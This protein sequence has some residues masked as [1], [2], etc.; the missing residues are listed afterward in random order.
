MNGARRIIDGRF[1]LLE[2]LGSGGMGTVW[3][4]RDTVLERDVA[5][6]EVRFA[7]PG[8]TGAEPDTR[9]VQHERVLREGRALARLRHPNVVAIH[10]VVDQDPYP[11]LVMEFVPGLS[12]Q[13]RLDKGP[14]DPRTAARIGRDMLAALRAAHAAGVH[15]RDIK[16]ANILLREGP[17][18][19]TAV[20]TD[21]GIA[22]LPGSSRLTHTGEMVGSPEFMAPERIRGAVD[23][24][25]SDL[26][27]LG[28]TLYVSVEGTSPM[29]RGT[30]LATLAAVLGD[31]VPAPVH[32]GPL[33]PVLARL[34]VAD[35]QDRP[36]VAEL[37]ALLTAVVDE[38][39]RPVAP[40]VR[41]SATVREPGPSAA[42]PLVRDARAGG[43]PDG[44]PPTARLVTPTSRRGP[45]RAGLVVGAAAVAVMLIAAASYLAL[46][47]DENGSARAADGVGAGATVT[48]TAVVPG[49]SGSP[50]QTSAASPG[51]TN[52]AGTTG[53]AGGTSGATDAGSSSDASG[54]AGAEEVAASPNAPGSP[55]STPTA[56]STGAATVVSSF[57]LR[58]KQ[59]GR[60]L[61]A[62]LYSAA[63]R[64]CTGGSAQT[65]SLDS[66]GALKGTHGYLTATAG[67]RVV[68]TAAEYTGD[69]LQHWTPVSSGQ[70]RNDETGDCLNVIGQETADGTQVAL[71][72]CTAK[73]NQVWIQVAR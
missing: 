73:A 2:R 34:L 55:A 69:G 10:H 65:W 21:F 42:T 37:D 26:W 15:H 30:S 64:T 19:T 56:T 59:S 51:S 17:G 7:E 54:A 60:C 28:M 32:A 3:R 18:H 38:P 57:A 70:I 16:P 68:K 66:N 29:R 25:A 35:P 61:T 41:E 24:P 36:D 27:S 20:L 1:E 9:R 46:S 50:G 39:S 44:L 71:Y 31:P 47:S 5:L 40:T 58:G 33:A 48:A 45:W 53:G 43:E 13:D 49:T 62:N 11:W 67:S 12:L 23:S 8:A 72:G 52:G 14:L 6:K 22:S 63:I 4:A